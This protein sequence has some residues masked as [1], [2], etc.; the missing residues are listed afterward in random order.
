MRSSGFI[1]LELV[2]ACAI[3]LL[4]GSAIMMVM[5]QINRLQPI[6]ERHIHP[7]ATALFFYNQCMRDI[8]GAQVPLTQWL[9]LSQGQ[10][11]EHADSD[12]KIPQIK[13]VFLGT[14][15][16]NMLDTLSFITT[17]PL[18][19]YWGAKTGKYIPRIVRVVYRLRPKKGSSEYVLLRQESEQLDLEKIPEPPLNQ[20]HQY[21][22]ADHIKSCTVEYS[23]AW[24][25]QDEAPKKPGQTPQQQEQS[26]KTH[27]EIRKKNE[28]REKQEEKSSKT[29]PA[30]ANKAQE[31]LLPQL[32]TFSF[33]FYDPSGKKTVPLTMTIPVYTEQI[34]E[35]LYQTPSQPSLTDVIK[36]L[37]SN[38]LPPTAQ[39]PPIQLAQAGAP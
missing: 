39:Q 37:S 36:K 17:N 11:T 27:Y 25:M 18:Q 8:S 9:A 32:V 19:S 20:W 28:W 21:I 10:K 35:P 22:L 7:V 12:Y 3:A 38:I 4:L 6:V 29:K 34:Y 5:Y 30:D 23:A 14:T 2:I 31:P 1:L 33:I 16:E 24:K 26:P 15:T 13:N